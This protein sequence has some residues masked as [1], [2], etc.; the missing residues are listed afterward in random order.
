MS[1]V[2]I[3]SLGSVHI[4][5]RELKPV[6]M[7]R[8]SLSVLNFLNTPRINLKCRINYLQ[9]DCCSPGLSAAISGRLLKLFVYMVTFTHGGFKGRHL[10]VNSEVSRPCWACEK[11]DGRS[12]PPVV[13]F[14]W[15]YSPPTLALY[16]QYSIN[17]HLTTYRV[18]KAKKCQL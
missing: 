15:F 9:S 1:T 7:L 10:G 11:V 13:G 14:Y 6:R 5:Q 3:T 12:H 8:V 18:S 17:H 2:V 16:R 4:L